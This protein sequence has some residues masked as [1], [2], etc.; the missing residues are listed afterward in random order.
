MSSAGSAAGHTLPCGGR[1][2]APPSTLVTSIGWTGRC[3]GRVRRHPRPDAVVR[4]ALVEVALVP[5]CRTMF[6]FG[7]N[8]TAVAGEDFT[9]QQWSDLDAAEVVMRSIYERRDLTF[10]RDDRLIPI[11]S[12]GGYE[13]IDSFG[14]FHD[15]LAT[16][17]GPTAITTSMHLSSRRSMSAAA[18]TESMAA[19]PDPRRMA[20]ATAASSRARPALSIPTGPGDSSPNI[21]EC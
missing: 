3:P 12:V 1:R 4:S 19:S 5:A 7:V 11:A 8:F 2:E 15:L 10:D 16:G 9:R 13:I 14:E 6:R 21:S 17:R 20:V 18:P